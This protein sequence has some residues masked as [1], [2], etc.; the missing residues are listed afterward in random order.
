MN[1]FKLLLGGRSS[2]FM[3]PP[4]PEINRPESRVAM[5]PITEEQAYQMGA[6]GSPHD[7]HERLCFEAYMRG[8]CW[9]YGEWDGK[10]YGDVG[11]RMLFGVWR[12]RAAIRHLIG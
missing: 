11:T 6:T 7:E 3:P 5:L 1:I 9:S 12:D 8:H 10:S 4:A 2:L